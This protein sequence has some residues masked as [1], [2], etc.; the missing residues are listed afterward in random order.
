MIKCLAGN[1]RPDSFPCS[2]QAG[3][4]F[5]SHHIAQLGVVH[6][7]KQFFRFQANGILVCI[8]SSMASRARKGTVLLHKALARQHLEYCWIFS[9]QLSLH[10]Q[11]QIN[12]LCVISVRIIADINLNVCPLLKLLTPCFL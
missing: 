5:T 4:G 6:L 7:P 1:E 8:R 9:N 3:K 11:P 12:L 2:G 10:T